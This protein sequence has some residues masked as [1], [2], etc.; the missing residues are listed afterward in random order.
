MR[1]ST[2]TWD[3]LQGG[4]QT[5]VGSCAGNDDRRRKEIDEVIVQARRAYVLIIFLEYRLLSRELGSDL[6]L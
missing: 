4:L 2:G 3:E 5:V 1:V 6:P